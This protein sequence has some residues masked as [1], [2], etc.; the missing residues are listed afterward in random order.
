MGSTATASSTTSCTTCAAATGSFKGLFPSS[1]PYT[2]QRPGHGPN[3]SYPPQQTQQPLPPSSRLQGLSLELANRR[4]LHRPSQGVTPAALAVAAAVGSS[5]TI[6]QKS[7]PPT[8]SLP[9]VF[10]LL[11]CFALPLLE[12]NFSKTCHLVAVKL[13]RAVNS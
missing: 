7:T 2:L 1:E 4:R 9:R 5:G 10:F 12:S 3:L 8:A 11:F 13:I 6:S